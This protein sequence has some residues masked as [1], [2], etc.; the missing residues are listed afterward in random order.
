MLKHKINVSA[1]ENLMLRRTTERTNHSF[2]QQLFKEIN[3]FDL[4]GLTMNNDRSCFTAGVEY[5][6]LGP[7]EYLVFYQNQSAVY[8]LQGML[9]IEHIY[10]QA[11][12]TRHLDIPLYYIFGYR[13]EF[14]LHHITL[15][16]NNK[17]SFESNLLTTEELVQF[18]HRIKGT[19]QTHP[20]N[21][22]GAEQRA[23]ETRIDRILENNDLAWGGNIDGFIIQDGEIVSII[24]CISIGRASQRNTGDLTDPV[25][26]PALYFHKK[27][28]K[29]ETW[30]STITL[31]TLLEVP[32]MLFTLDTVNTELETIGLTGIDFLTKSGINY[33]NRISPNENVI[34]GLDNIVNA[35]FTLISRLNV[36]QIRLGNR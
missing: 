17:I 35:I 11:L 24:D 22:N 33:F 19:I 8:N 7:D 31:A 5:F 36:P 32:H 2:Q 9:E 10:A 1:G 34:H 23:N 15:N 20:I 3:A 18:W 14:Y 12:L 16:N 29:Y 30:K 21:L 13:D 27:G 28:P 26:D 4:Q 25:A 6:D